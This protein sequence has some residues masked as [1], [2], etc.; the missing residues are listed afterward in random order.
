MHGKTP[1]PKVS[2]DWYGNKHE[3]L[4]VVGQGQFYKITVE[5]VSDEEAT[6]YLGERVSKPTPYAYRLLSAPAGW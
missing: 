4:T 2:T 3:D 6:R 5:P 1:E